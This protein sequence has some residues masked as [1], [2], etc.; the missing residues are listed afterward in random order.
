MEVRRIPME[1]LYHLLE[2]QLD[3]HNNHQNYALLY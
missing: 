2:E 3:K 1:E